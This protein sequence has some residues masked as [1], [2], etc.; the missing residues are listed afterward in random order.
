[1]RELAL[2]DLDSSRKRRLPRLELQA[3]VFGP[4]SSSAGYGLKGRFEKDPLR[5]HDLLLFAL[6]EAEIAT[7][8][9][10]KQDETGFYDSLYED[11][12]PFN[13][14]A[15]H[16]ADSHYE[17]IAAWLAGYARPYLRGDERE[18][19]RLSDMLTLVVQEG[20]WRA[21][22]R[23]RGASYSHSAYNRPSPS[24][25][26]FAVAGAANPGRDAV[27]RVCQHVFRTLVNAKAQDD[28][29]WREPLLGLAQQLATS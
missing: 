24:Q 27:E 2:S 6:A 20:G 10:R 17:V 1:V 16:S 5:L 15:A 3:E 29:Q 23:A 7:F 12:L 14:C 22:E 4:L 21:D 28:G 18:A 8:S 19:R 9:H 25:A 11:I 26:A 13:D